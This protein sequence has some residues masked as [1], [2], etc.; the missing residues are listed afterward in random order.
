M[1]TLHRLA[2]LFGGI[3]VVLFGIHSISP[4]LLN[5]CVLLLSVFVL[6]E[7]QECLF[8][9][10]DIAEDQYY[11]SAVCDPSPCDEGEECRLTAV[12]CSAGS[13]CGNG[14]VC[15]PS[16][17]DGE[18]VQETVVGDCSACGEFQVQPQCVR[19]FRCFA[20]LWGRSRPSAC[21]SVEGAVKRGDCV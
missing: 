6:L 1:S 15:S 17:D 10:G 2:Q 18:V 5:R 3:C 16:D 7:L 21:L 14:Y 11:C 12:G 19:V 4:N 20:C 13:V 9:T 8:Y